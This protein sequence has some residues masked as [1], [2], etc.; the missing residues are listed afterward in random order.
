MTVAVYWKWPNRWGSPI[1][2]G[3]LPAGWRAAGRHE[4]AV[5]R[6]PLGCQFTFI[7]TAMLFDT[8]AEALAA[9]RR[10]LPEDAHGVFRE[11]NLGALAT[12]PAAC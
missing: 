3:E 7:P 12:T 2:R 1:E 5:P 4:E 11:Y 6:D 9:A 10:Q 8:A